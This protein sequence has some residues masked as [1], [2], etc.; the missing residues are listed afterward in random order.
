MPRGIYKRKS[1]DLPNGP[2]AFAAAAA[3]SVAEK[4]KK[5]RQAKKRTKLIP[6]SAIPKKPEPR[7]APP[8]KQEDSKI[9]L[10]TALVHLVKFLVGAK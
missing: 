1:H 6:L 3:A 8:R 10:A 4:P 7:R 9:V 5:K 2:E